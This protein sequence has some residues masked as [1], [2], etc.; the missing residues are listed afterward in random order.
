MGEV[1]SDNPEV[2]RSEVITCTSVKDDVKTIDLIIKHFSSCI[3][4]KKC[5][6]WVLR[7]KRNVLEACRSRKNGRLTDDNRRTV[8][9]AI[10]IDGMKTAER[11]LL[12]HVQKTNFS[13][14]LACC[15]E[16]VRGTNNL[17]RGTRVKKTSPI[18]K[19]DPVL[20]DGILRVG[21]RL[22]HAMIPEDAKHQ[23]IIPKCHHVTDLIVRHYHKISGHSSRDYYVLLLLRENFG[24]YTQTRLFEDY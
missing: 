2:K 7:Y 17:T 3:W 12:K 16:D 18:F 10:T 23:V 6:A 8:I 9:Q 20:I 13:D 5:I 15:G 22:Q 24:S 4:L 14:E 11:V 19:L 1:S 21:G